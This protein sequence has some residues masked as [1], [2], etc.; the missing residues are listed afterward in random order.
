MASLVDEVK[1]PLERWLAR[2]KTRQ[3]HRRSPR[4]LSFTD[5]NVNGYTEATQFQHTFASYIRL[6]PI[7]LKVLLGMGQRQKVRILRHLDGLVRPGEM[8]LVLGRPGSGCT[9]FLKTMAG[10]VHGLEVD[11]GKINYQG[12]SFTEMHCKFRG[13]SIYLAENDVHFPELTLG[14]TLSFAAEMRPHGELSAREVG[15]LSAA[16]FGLEQSLHTQVGNE[17]VRGLSGGEKRRT[18]I[19]EA[20]LSRCPIQCWDNSTRGLDSATALNFVRMLRRATDTLRSTVM[21]TIYQAPEVLYQKFDKV[22]LLYEGRQI[23]FGPTEEAAEYFIRSGFV[24]PA[25]A[26]T[27]D[28]LTSL[29]NANERIVQPGFEAR[30]PR[31]PDEFAAAWRRSPESQAVRKETEEFSRLHPPLNQGSRHPAVYPTTIVHQIRTCV[32]R[33]FVRSRHNVPGLVS[34]V[35][36]NTILA[37]ILGSVFYN[38]AENTDSFQARSILIFYATMMNSCLPAF[39]VNSLWAQRPIVEKHTRYAFYHP[40]AEGIS[41][42]LADLPVKVVTSLFFNV[43]IYF[44]T[45]LRRSTAAFF[46]FWLFGFVVMVTMSMIFRSVGSLSRTY[47][48]S[49]APVSIMIFNFI[50]YAGFV[51]P[52]HYQVPWLSWIRWFNP[53]AYANESLMINEFRNRQFPCSATVP[54]GPTYSDS[55]MNGKV[56]SA[57][58]SVHGES[59]VEGNQFLKLKYGY[60]VDHLWR[61]L[62]IL[63]ALMVSFCVVHLLA[64]EYIQAEK[65]KGDILLFR[66]KDL[67]HRLP[68]D[69]ESV[70]GSIQTKGIT[71]HRP[72][73]RRG[74]DVLIEGLAKQSSAFYWSNVG[75]EVQVGKGLSRILDGIDGWVARGTL[76]ALM[77]STGAGKT[78]LLDV[79]ANRKSVGIVH[80]DVRID[81]RPRDRCFQRKTGY[82]QQADIHLRSATVREALQFSAL[83]RQPRDRSRA[84]KLS[85]VDTVLNMLEMESY[86]DSVV[87]VPG[88]GLNIEQRKRLTIAIEMAARP[89]LLL[90]LD[91]PTSGLDSQTAWSICILLRKL[92]DNGQAILCTI[93]QPSAELFQMFDRLLLLKG[94]ARYPEEGENPAEW[95]LEVTSSSSAPEWSEIWSK[96]AER[97]AVQ[98]QIARLGTDAQ[99]SEGVQETTTSTTTLGVEDHD[100]AAPSLQQLWLVTYRMFQDYWRDPTY[101]YSKLAL[102]VGAALFNG[103]SFW[104]LHK[105][106]QGLTSSLFSCFLLTIIFNTVDQQII[107]RFIDNRD[108]FEAREKPSKTYN[109]IVFVAA[110]M[111]VELVWQSLTSVLVFVAWYYPTG[112]W[113][114]G[115]DDGNFTMSQRAILVFLLIWLFFVFSSTLSQ[116]IAAGMQ[117]SLTAVNIANLLFTLCLIFC[118]ILV[119]PGALPR[120]WIFMY[121]VSPVTYLMDG[122]IIAALANTKLHCA[123]IDLLR[124][125]LPANATSCGDYMTAYVSTTGGMVLNPNATVGDCLFCSVADTNS[126]LEALGI[127]ITGQWRDLGFL[128]VYVVVNI[129][130]TFFLYWVARVPK[131]TKQA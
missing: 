26:T 124:I 25:R 80:G 36:G 64:A 95:L 113:R 42:I 125:T 3:N 116:A 60:T 45:N 104:M 129:T 65:S 16:I 33:A 75:Y 107:P 5:A 46:I 120:F 55:S 93:H 105:D 9:T 54:S 110:N 13:D 70:Q 37:I 17:M 88:K 87:G 91:E 108:Q 51:I 92:A 12:I 89:E 66:R 24:R 53:I 94:G 61:N 85:Y 40:V 7:Y 19:A 1:D 128:A 118:G 23:Y 83:L 30:V 59:S 106:V 57:I 114:N 123:T 119:Q 18:S 79:L 41:S 49:L 39:E 99:K 77:G 101:L 8:L 44:L 112:F 127:D 67:S 38:L 10:D 126:A 32:D 117:D 28:F 84:Q 62:G 52:P 97:E 90:F 68:G 74:S 27:A 11:E 121:R 73:P 22:L 48:Q 96:S 2:K 100:Y 72:S 115:L 122:M 58:G 50:I 69:E 6:L 14:E 34:G 15:P 78:T 20:F 43:C 47:A 4:G 102:C 98:L 109:W 35:V 130:A 71:E 103:L 82:V 56:C 76:T 81:G 31:T 21:T 63:F 111:I 29:T 131:G 86:A